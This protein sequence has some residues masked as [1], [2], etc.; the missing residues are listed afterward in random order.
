MVAP[1]VVAL[2]APPDATQPEV[3]SPPTQENNPGKVHC[4]KC[5]SSVQAVED[6]QYVQAPLL[7]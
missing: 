6:L 3:G 7:I 5:E 1:T 2:L 4:V